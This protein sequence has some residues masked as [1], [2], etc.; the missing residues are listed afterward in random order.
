M[1]KNIAR[2]GDTPPAPRKQESVNGKQE[3]NK[4]ELRLVVVPSKD[5]K[6]VQS[7]DYEIHPDLFI[8]L[9][10]VVFPIG[11]I[12]KYIDWLKTKSGDSFSN[13]VKSV[14]QSDE[15]LVESIEDLLKDY[16][17]SGID[18]V[19]ILKN[20][21]F[22]SIDFEDKVV[23][24][25][26]LTC[27][28]RKD[29]L[30][31]EFVIP[32]LEKRIDIPD[33]ELNNNFCINLLSLQDSSTLKETLSSISYKDIKNIDEFAKSLIKV[34]EPDFILDTLIYRLRSLTFS[35]ED[36]NDN[37]IE[38]EKIIKI[39]LGILREMD[40][41]SMPLKKA[42]LM[43]LYTMSINPEIA[44]ILANFQIKHHE[45]DAP[46]L[47]KSQMY[48]SSDKTIVGRSRRFHAISHFAQYA[49][50]YGASILKDF[51]KE[52]KDS[53]LVGSACYDLVNSCGIDGQRA[54]V[55]LTNEDIRLNKA[56]IPL[57]ILTQMVKFG[58]PYNSIFK[59]I[60]AQDFQKGNDLRQAYVNLM[61]LEV[62]SINRFPNG[63]ISFSRGEDLKQELILDLI[64]NIGVEQFLK[65]MANGEFKE[66]KHIENV[67]SNS[68]DIFNL[69]WETNKVRMQELILETLPLCPPETMSILTRLIGINGLEKTA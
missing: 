17:K 62:C 58:K 35:Y 39:A 68:R 4:Q 54:L 42:H 40:A 26:V 51:V 45:P 36:N 13:R 47:F 60:L 48:D 10:N 65:W 11:G 49:K 63:A 3:G 32:S 23:I 44:K 22:K 25:K 2:V 12:R 18:L 61:P 6:T 66:T 19:P 34:K 53:F 46:L 5:T 41:A 9:R 38:H 64:S 24:V 8:G 7:I 14:L 55:S 43:D 16:S 37:L 20:M 1:A 59:A 33:V 52:E 27:L 28:E 15:S 69:A 56:S 50:A 29:E 30:L 67:K 57:A 31:S 21:L